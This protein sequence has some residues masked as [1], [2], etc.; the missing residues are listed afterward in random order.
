MKTDS[1]DQ[2]V[3]YKEFAA[4][5]GNAV[6][7]EM[8]TNA[9]IFRFFGISMLIIFFGVL[10]Y[11][12]VIGL[13]LGLE[14]IALIFDPAY[15]LFRNILR[16]Q[17]VPPHLVKP[18]FSLILVTCLLLAF[19]SLFIFI[20]IRGFSSSGFC[21]QSLVCILVNFVHRLL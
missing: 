1:R 12:I 2:P 3:S 7:R 20:G 9:F 18:P 21:A 13:F 4:L 10:V 15:Q 5:F 17:N 11:C 6:S 16:L 19:P 8:S 14:L